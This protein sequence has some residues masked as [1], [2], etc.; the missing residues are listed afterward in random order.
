MY[1]RFLRLGAR[2]CGFGSLLSTLLIPIYATGAARGLS[3][4]QFN[5]LT[6]ARVE[7]G[8]TWR[9]WV[10]VF[11]W[12]IFI[13][14]V[15]REFWNEWALYYK[16][17][18]HFAARGDEDMP[19]ECRY[20]VR[21]EQVGTN[22]DDRLRQYFNRLF[23]EQVADTAACIDTSKIDAC[24]QKRDKLLVKVESMV[25]KTRADPS[26]P[27]PLI[28]VK[29]KKVDAIGHLMKEIERMNAEVD[30]A[31]SRVVKESST[32]FVTFKTLRT[33]QA[34]IQCELTGDPDSIVAFPSADPNSTIWENVYVPIQRQKMSQFLLSFVWSAGILFWA[35]PVTFVTAMANL[36]SILKSF[37]LPPV[38]ETTFW[39]GLLAGLLPVIFLAILMAVLYMAIEVG[40]KRI[41][42][43]KSMPE[44]DSY[45][46][47]WHMLFQFANLWLILIGGSL[48]NQIDQVLN[49]EEGEST[50]ETQA[51]LDF[52]DV[53]ATALPGASTFF[54]N[55]IIVASFGAFGMELSMIPTYATTLIFR[56]L[57]PEA[58]RTQRQI[59]DAKSPPSI[60]W[61][62]QIPP[63]IFIFLVSFLYMPIVPLMEVFGLVYFVG[64][65]IVWK[66][67]CLHVYAQEF[68]G[69]GEATWQK[70]FGFLMA[71]LY[72]GEGVFISFM[73]IKQAPIQA[74]L[75]FVPLAVTAYV[76]RA[77]NRKF[78]APTKN[79][80]L[81][82]AATVDIE[83]G[84]LID[85][86]P[87]AYRQPVADEENDEREPMPYRRES[88]PEEVSPEEAL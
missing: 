53:I 59:D 16:N 73:G 58:A 51:I 68:E 56:I 67:Q 28:R 41:I 6:L 38:D 4:V 45:T 3:T 77:L 84:D 22:T 13:A 9:V 75:G 2:I 37:R 24:I 39:Y 7:S 27:R 18:S 17:R 86:T 46:L 25:A 57:S 43:L 10:T 60:I 40:A 61:G 30:A 19:K 52:L 81:E 31:R 83:D 32:A 64:S 80:S 82:A 76:H 12:W 78:I 66:H 50:S 36:N 5:L 34:A 26:K 47:Y 65:Y 11:S 88:K 87:G 54:M 20:T 49:S 72:I 48:F 70:V 42:R 44:V 79:L 69:G 21:C 35:V 62:Q 8:S 55:M 1:L 85:N 63:I 29:G 23:P 33:K 15:L 74:S 14:F 71:C